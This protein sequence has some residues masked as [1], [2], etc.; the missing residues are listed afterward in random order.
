MTRSAVDT[1]DLAVRALHVMSTEDLAAFEELIDPRATNRE[2]IDEPPDCRGGGPAAF[3]A[4]ARWLHAAFSDLRWEIHDVVE[5]GDL[6]VLHATM[7]GN[8]SGPFVGYGPDARPK[9]AFPPT[10]RTFATTQTHWFRIADQKVIEHWANRD[11]RGMGEQLGWT[12]PS[13]V[14]LL[15]MLLAT[16]KARAATQ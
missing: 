9:I 10:G 14:Y 4:T 13:P 6:V 2:A 1:K 16:R 7:S 12:P 5:D 11:D 15:R 8:H 3:L